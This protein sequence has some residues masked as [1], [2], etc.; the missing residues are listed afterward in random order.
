[1]LS[2]KK[3]HQMKK[4]IRDDKNHPHKNPDH[5]R[6]VSGRAVDVSQHCKM[7]ILV[8]QSN[9]NHW[10]L[11]KSSQ[12]EHLFH[13]ELDNK[14]KVLGEK[15]LEPL[16][17]DWYICACPAILFNHVDTISSLQMYI[18]HFRYYKL[19]GKH[20]V[21][22]QCDSRSNFQLWTPC[23]KASLVHFFQRQFSTSLKRGGHFLVWQMAF[24]NILLMLRKQ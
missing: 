16:T 2:K 5:R 3:T 23:M 9:D 8:V 21:R 10:H 20:P 6:T 19:V 17:F 1:M 15:D 18:L 12:L 11:H 22:C 24:L 13:A 4:K 7:S 14:A